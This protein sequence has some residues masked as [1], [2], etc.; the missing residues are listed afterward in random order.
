LFKRKSCAEYV[1]TVAEN[2]WFCGVATMFW[3]GYG[4]AIGVPMRQSDGAASRRLYAVA[5]LDQ[6]AA[7]S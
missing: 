5:T 3:L 4:R 1:T 2:A 7:P 6:G